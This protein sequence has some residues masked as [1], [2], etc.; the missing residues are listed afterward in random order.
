MT[1]EARRYPQIW[2]LVLGTFAAFFI[3]LTLLFTF[4]PAATLLLGRFLSAGEMEAVTGIAS[5]DTGASPVSTFILLISFVALIVG[6]AVAAKIHH[7]SLRSLCGIGYALRPRELGLGLGVVIIFK[8]LSDVAVGGFSG[9]LPNLALT[10]W[11]LWLVPAL[12]AVFIQTFA[13]ELIF[14]GYLQQQLAAISMNPLVWWVLPSVLFGLLHLDA[15]TW[16][17][18]KWLVVAATILM[19]LIAGDVTARTG[20]I[21]AALGLHFG[22]NLMAVLIVGT[23]GQLG[24]LSL[25]PSPV[26]PSDIEATRAGLI[27]TIIPMA[28]AYAI[29]LFV[30]T[31]QK[32]QPDG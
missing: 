32:S 18:N 24:G 1:V 30:V 16:G 28:L 2:R 27:A 3:A 7:R 29:Y 8:T 13:E 14:R 5:P 26:S 20:N 17:E 21:S 6:A 23:P 15:E 19:G 11:A 25:W 4:V 22:N 10:S 9:L 31:R 12:I